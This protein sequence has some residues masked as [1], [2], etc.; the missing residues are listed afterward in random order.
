MSVFLLFGI[1]L[2]VFLSAH[3]HKLELA[4]ANA[5]FSEKAQTFTG[6]LQRQLQEYESAINATEAFFVSSNFVNQQE[7][8]LFVYTLL[9]DRPG[10]ENVMFIPEV[11]QSNLKTFQ[12]KKSESYKDFTLKSIVDNEIGAFSS[13]K[14]AYH[15]P[16]FYIEPYSRYK[17]YIGLDI[18]SFPLFSKTMKDI[19]NTKNKPFV[20][21]LFHPLETQNDQFFSVFNYYENIPINNSTTIDPYSTQTVS[22]KN[23]SHA[24]VVVTFDIASTIKRLLQQ[25]EYASLSVEASVDLFPETVQIFNHDNQLN[26]DALHSDSFEQFSRNW[27]VQYWPKAEYYYKKGWAEY[28]V[29]GGSIMLF[30]I[31]TAY[32]YSL[33]KQREKDKVFTKALE[34]EKSFLAAIMNN[35]MQGVITVKKDG[36]IKTF[37]K[38]AEHIFGYSEEDAIGQDL[39]K[40]V[41]NQNKIKLGEHYIVGI[42]SEVEA[43]RKDGQTFPMQLSI[44]EIE[45]QNEPIFIGLAADISEQKEKEKALRQ[46][47]EDADEANQAKSEFLA[48]MSHELRTPLNSILGLSRML[49]E[50]KELSQDNKLM[51]DTVLKSAENLLKIVDDIL[52]VSKIEFGSISLEHIGFDIKGSI[53]S[54]LEVMTPLASEKNI[55]LEC[56]FSDEHIPFVYGDPLRFSRVIT[57]L[58]GNAIKYTNEGKIVL[59]ISAHR[60]K[61]DAANKIEIYCDITD[62]GIGISEDKFEAI[63]EKFTQSDA[64][65]TRKYGGTGLGLSIT[66]DLVTLM[67]GVIG[68]ESE[69][70][71]GSTFWFNIPFD[72]AEAIDGSQYDQRKYGRDSSHAYLEP[73]KTKVL[74]AEDH[75][76]NQDFIGRL[77]RQIGLENFEI[78]DD[79]QA[80]LE[81]FQSKKYDLALMD[82]H[83]PKKSGYEVV[84]EIRKSDSETP[85]IAITADAMKG[86]REKCLKVGMN[87]YVTKPISPDELKG[88]LSQWIILPE[89]EYNQNQKPE[90]TK[91][92]DDMPVN[93]GVMESFAD[94]EEDILNFIELFMKESKASI[95]ILKKQ[96]DNNEAFDWSEAAHKL[97]GGSGMIGAKKLHELS[98]EAEEM[99]KNETAD[100]EAFFEKIEDEYTRVTECLLERVK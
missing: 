59:Q 44:T 62:T 63:F 8:E 77:L 10:V 75:L 78:V 100:R 42:N 22:G 36:S 28:T 15:Y 58:V 32:A 64:S 83:M 99:G 71:N 14:N 29:L 12:Q 46:A 24:F 88:V 79:G 81:A 4:Q 73:E 13:V 26:I 84:E 90:Q 74:V 52:D 60:H 87:D 37:N 2:S 72:V 68:V 25:E 65:D 48:N 19:L 35:M 80:A 11:S 1:G 43:L 5:V 55:S 30:L 70:D 18:S 54:V 51:A 56:N 38:W 21:N 76:L 94:T 89:G 66:K 69:I 20:T 92:K 27:T 6:L 39:K 47:K 50:E 93:W 85:I 91:Q 41:P 40:L 57:N 96:R 3:V 95:K 45:E 23:Q 17:D 49:T 98:A 33:L 86:A 67:G 9:F 61:T 53:A 31:I 7:F 34:A 82:C 16:I 97:K